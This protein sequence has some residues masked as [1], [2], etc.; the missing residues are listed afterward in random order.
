M[1]IYFFIL[2]F[3][4]YFLTLYPYSVQKSTTEKCIGVNS[5]IKN[6]TIKAITT[7]VKVG[8]IKEEALNSRPADRNN[9]VV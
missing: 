6:M 7:I 1:Q 4:N 8:A 3:E 2:F 5:S 9:W